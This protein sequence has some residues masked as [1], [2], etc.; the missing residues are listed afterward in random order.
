MVATHAA[1][2]VEV[3]L[4]P[5]VRDQSLVVS[6]VQG[7]YEEEFSAT[8]FFGG[9]WFRP[10]VVLQSDRR[11]LATMAPIVFGIILLAFIYYYVW[12]RKVRILENV[13]HLEGDRQ[14]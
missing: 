14:V 5:N 1:G 8:A 9:A 7:S 11:R 3:R 13:L 10:K 4:T 12:Q 2:T 6:A